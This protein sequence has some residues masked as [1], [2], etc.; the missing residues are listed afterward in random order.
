MTIIACP[1]ALD[2]EWTICSPGE[3]TE[4]LYPV[5]LE[6]SDSLGGYYFSESGYAAVFSRSSISSGHSIWT[7]ASPSLLTL[8]NDSLEITLI[9]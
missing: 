8:V 3:E 5:G 2:A 9:G 4:W 6:Y 7:D 1:T